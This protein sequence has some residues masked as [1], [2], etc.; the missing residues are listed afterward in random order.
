MKKLSILLLLASL[1][2][3]MP[4][5]EEPYDF[6]AQLEIDVALIEQYLAETPIEGRIERSETGV[7]VIITNEG[8]GTVANL[9]DFVTIDF[10]GRVFPNEN[11]FDTTFEG[12]A[13]NNDIYVEGKRY[14][15]YTFELGKEIDGLNIAFSFLERK[16]TGLIIIPSGYA[17]GPN[18]SPLVPANSILI[19]DFNYRAI[20]GETSNN[21]QL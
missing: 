6:Q 15:P 14:E 21:P 20:N 18:D 13:R 17:Y 9:A 19:F 7:V 4:E 2:A 8:D 3:C 11:V 16:S 1:M 5:P 12:V 10:T